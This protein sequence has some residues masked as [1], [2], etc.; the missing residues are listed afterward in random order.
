M[1][2]G[3]RILVSFLAITPKY[4]TQMTLFD[5]PEVGS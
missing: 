3:Q 2:P 4:E 1:G 5:D